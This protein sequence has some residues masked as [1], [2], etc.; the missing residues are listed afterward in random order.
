MKLKSLM[1]WL[2]VAYALCLMP[3]SCFNWFSAG[4]SLDVRG[5]VTWLSGDLIEWAAHAVLMGAVA[6]HLVQVFGRSARGLIAVLYAVLG[7]LLIAVSIEGLQSILPESFHR[8]FSWSDVWA[9]L[10][11]GLVAGCVAMVFAG[12]RREVDG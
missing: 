6:Y 5:H 2:L 1:V 4:G 9:S 11:G 3:S 12:S 8:G 10:L 7:V